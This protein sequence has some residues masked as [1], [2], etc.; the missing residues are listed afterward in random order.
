[1]PA[2]PCEALAPQPASGQRLHFV[3]GLVFRGPSVPSRAAWL[4]RAIPS[5][6]FRVARLRL[7]TP[8]AVAAS[9][10][11]VPRGHWAP[12]DV[13]RTLLIFR[14]AESVE[15]YLPVRGGPGVAPASTSRQFTLLTHLET[16][17]EALCVDT[18]CQLISLFTSKSCRGSLRSLP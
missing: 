10:A 14:S 7:L 1:M 11:Q 8:A 16:H 12:L 3:T 9:A 2:L 17:L 4:A 6:L 18:L 15:S 5:R 13:F